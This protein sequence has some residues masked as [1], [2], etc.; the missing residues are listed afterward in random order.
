MKILIQLS[1][2][3]FSI[4]LV[5]LTL[6]KLGYEHKISLPN[7]HE[8]G[9]CLTAGICITETPFYKIRLNQ[10]FSSGCTVQGEQGKVEVS[11]GGVIYV[12]GPIYIDGCEVGMQ[13]DK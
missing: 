3:V 4:C 12:Q 6:D 8:P 1:S 10:D 7:L 13:F 9:P 5:C 11:S 2:L